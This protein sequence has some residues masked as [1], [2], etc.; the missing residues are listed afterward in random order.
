MLLSSKDARIAFYLRDKVT[1]EEC[2]ASLGDELEVH[3]RTNLPE[4]P[5]QMV[6]YAHFLRDRYADEGRDVSVFVYAVAELNSHPP[7]LFVDPDVDLAAQKR[8]LTYSWVYDMGEVEARQPLRGDLPDCSEW[9]PE[10]E[11]L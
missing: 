11:R 1:G 2:R 8:S 9:L 6:Q 7:S 4:R 5:D 10:P 3:Q